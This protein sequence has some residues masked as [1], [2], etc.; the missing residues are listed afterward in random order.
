MQII[1]SKQCE[2][3]SE[4]EQAL[5]CPNIF[6]ELITAWTKWRIE[7]KISTSDLDHAINKRIHRSVKF[8]DQESKIKSSL[9]LQSLQTT[10][11]APTHFDWNILYDM[12]YNQNL[13]AWAI[14][15]EAQQKAACDTENPITLFQKLELHPDALLLDHL[16]KYE[17]LKHSTVY[18]SNSSCFN[19]EAMILTILHLFDQPTDHRP[20]NNRTQALRCK[21]PNSIIDIIE[22]DPITKNEKFD[23]TRNKSPPPYNDYARFY[24]SYT[25]ACE[26][27]GWKQKYINKLKLAQILAYSKEVRLPIISLGY[28]LF[29]SPDDCACLQLFFLIQDPSSHLITKNKKQSP[30]FDDPNSSGAYAAAAGLLIGLITSFEVGPA[31]PVAMGV[32]AGEITILPLLGLLDA[33]YVAI[34]GK[35]WITNSEASTRSRLLASLAAV[36]GVTALALGLIATAPASVVFALTALAIGTEILNRVSLINDTYELMEALS[37]QSA[38]RQKLQLED[39]KA[40]GL[41]QQSAPRQSPPT[42][43]SN[44]SAMSWEQYQDIIAADSKPSNKLDL[45][46]FNSSFEKPQQTQ[47]NTTTTKIQLTQ[48]ELKTY[49]HHMGLPP[50]TIKN[51][52]CFITIDEKPSKAPL[53]SETL[54]QIC[55]Q[56][57]LG[58]DFPVDRIGIH[59]IEIVLGAS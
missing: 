57:K 45:P 42:I 44:D 49:E 27:I 55:A 39:L 13:E 7:D 24:S 47:S 29:K 8:L 25:R 10:H 51:G 23:P 54:H 26:A 32:L 38:K 53:P 56:L 16:L 3:L 33:G 31:I 1:Q 58:N 43:N 36:F 37:D 52:D 35:D 46:P 40:R 50:G 2:L 22:C 21:L 34:T 19:C 17:L 20:T 41:L 15:Q 28:P 5:A 12:R 18:I 30:P 48:R 59:K 11:F 4:L 9:T 6:Q 14:N